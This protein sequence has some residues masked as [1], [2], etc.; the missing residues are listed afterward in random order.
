MTPA[1]GGGRLFYSLC[2][3]RPIRARTTADPKYVLPAVSAF[4]C[5]GITP[6]AGDRPR[7][8]SLPFKQPESCAEQAFE[9]NI[10]LRLDDDHPLNIRHQLHDH[11]IMDDES[12]DAVNRLLE[13][14]ID[15]A[16]TAAALRH[17]MR[18]VGHIA[19]LAERVQ[20]DSNRFMIMP[21]IRIFR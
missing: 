5:P 20:V 2:G 17:G 14:V 21:I 8:R 6:I 16:G 4:D 10:R 9:R 1:R 3:R 18:A 13:R 7:H 11:R 12:H 15:S 19:D